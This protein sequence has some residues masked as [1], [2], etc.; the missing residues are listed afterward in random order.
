MNKIECVLGCDCFLEVLSYLGR[1]D[2]ESYDGEIDKKLLWKILVGRDFGGVYVSQRMVMKC[3]G[4]YGVYMCLEGG[5]R[6]KDFI[7]L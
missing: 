5:M 2:L 7:S 3:G 1:E 6:W 4:W